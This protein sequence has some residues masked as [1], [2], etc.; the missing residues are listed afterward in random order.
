M[1]Y[2]ECKPKYTE[3]GGICVELCTEAPVVA[4]ATNKSLAECVNTTS[5]TNCTV[6]CVKNAKPGGGQLRCE[7]GNFTS[8]NVCG[9][10]LFFKHMLYAV[11]LGGQSKICQV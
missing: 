1:L 11:I 9:T 5:G 4:L 2:V 10:L 8:M 6:E 7:A 3:S